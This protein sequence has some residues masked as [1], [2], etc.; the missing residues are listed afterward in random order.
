MNIDELKVGKKFIK[1]EAS[2]CGI[3]KA[4]EP[5]WKSFS[6]SNENKDITFVKINLDEYPDASEM[7]E[8]TAI[9]AFI[10]LDNGV[11]KG[12]L[13]GRCDKKQLSELKSYLE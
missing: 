7:F 9:P 13:I 1:V 8:I 6:E 11:E 12:R 3:C 10:A 4:M 2:L 5:T